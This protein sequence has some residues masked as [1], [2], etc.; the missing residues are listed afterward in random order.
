MYEGKKEEKLPDAVLPRLGARINYFSL[1]CVRQLEK[2]G[3]LVLNN[4]ES[5]EMSRDKLYTL[6]TCTLL[7]K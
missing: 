3:I 7:A 2:M 5:L 6:Q 4:N 1:A